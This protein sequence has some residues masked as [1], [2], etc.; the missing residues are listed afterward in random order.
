MVAAG[1]SGRAT[2]GWSGPCDRD[3]DH[4]RGAADGG[5][6]AQAVAGQRMAAQQMEA[7]G[8]AAGDMAEDASALLERQSAAVKDGLDRAGARVAMLRHAWD[9]VFSALR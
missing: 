4:G 8:A 6:G 1:S 7:A 3:D 2:R 9:E 5:D